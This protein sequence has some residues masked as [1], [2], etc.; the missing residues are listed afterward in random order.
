MNQQILKQFFDHVLCVQDWKLEKRIVNYV[1]SQFDVC[2]WKWTIHSGKIQTSQ[3]NGIIY[4]KTNGS[5][6]T[7]ILLHLDQ[8]IFIIDT[9]SGYPTPK[10]TA[11][12]LRKSFN[13]QKYILLKIN[14]YTTH[15]GPSGCCVAFSLAALILTANK[16][17]DSVE[18]L[19]LCFAL[20]ATKIKQ[21]AE[22]LYMDRNRWWKGHAY[23]SQWMQTLFKPM[24]FT[25][26]T[27]ERENVDEEYWKKNFLQREQLINTSM[28]K[29]HKKQTE[30]KL[31][32][33]CYML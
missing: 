20:L 7:V 14:Q 16:T 2:N 26:H 5:W 10:G 9:N 1:C 21:N 17:I 30:E 6:H 32:K 12:M 27:Q 4:F 19:R 3:R 15:K 33:L 11:N 31:R 18:E 28:Y 23:Y 25:D 8:R 29:K 24:N 13:A 22:T